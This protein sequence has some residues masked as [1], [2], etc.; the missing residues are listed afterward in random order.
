MSRAET[1]MG[2][3]YKRAVARGFDER[4]L[5]NLPAQ[6]EHAKSASNVAA[7]MGDASPSVIGGRLRVLGRAGECVRVE[8][9][10]VKWWRS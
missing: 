4:I 8:G 7:D 10:P 5:S 1:R 3:A 2:A 6:A 9:R